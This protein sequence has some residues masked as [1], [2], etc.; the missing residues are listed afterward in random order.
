MF[1]NEATAIT[2]TS[3]VFI[4]EAPNPEHINATSSTGDNSIFAI[5]LL[6]GIV[7]ISGAYIKI[8]TRRMDRK[9]S[10]P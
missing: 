10:R 7:L 1:D 4:S 3:G 8:S 5:M 2:G 9:Y 6:I